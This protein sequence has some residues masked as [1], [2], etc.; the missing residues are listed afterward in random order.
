MT[1]P[2]P[3]K[4]TF[5]PRANVAAG[6]MRAEFIYAGFQWAR[7]VGD[8]V[9]K[10][11]NAG[12][13]AISQFDHWAGVPELGHS[14]TATSIF[15]CVATLGAAAAHWLKVGRDR[16]E[17]CPDEGSRLAG[18]AGVLGG[19]ATGLAVNATVFEGATPSPVTA[20][21]ASAAATAGTIIVTRS[22]DLR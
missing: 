5:R 14:P 11:F 19:L 22:R 10:T 17:T 18:A 1:A 6:I 16:A 20:L 4:R 9:L 13:T 8:F 7:V 21:L 2:T 15:A 3:P 12:S